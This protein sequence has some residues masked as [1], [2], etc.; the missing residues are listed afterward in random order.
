MGIEVPSAGS[1]ILN[2]LH[3]WQVFFRRIKRAAVLPCRQRRD[4]REKLRHT[5]WQGRLFSAG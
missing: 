5:E 4:Q 2:I 1:Y 3:F